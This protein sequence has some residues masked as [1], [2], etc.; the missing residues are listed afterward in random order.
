MSEPTDINPRKING[1]DRISDGLSEYVWNVAIEAARSQYED[2]I[3][4]LEE[5]LAL[6]RDRILP[7]EPQSIRA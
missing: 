1:H 2:R 3:F 4:A 6:I 5:D 7:S